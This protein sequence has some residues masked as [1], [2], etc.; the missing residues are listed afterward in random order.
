MNHV[1]LL[2]EVL[3]KLIWKLVYDL[4]VYILI[5]AIIGFIVTSLF[6]LSEY[7]NKSKTNNIHRSS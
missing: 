4:S 3:F 7:F 2:I 5:I 6:G 1:S